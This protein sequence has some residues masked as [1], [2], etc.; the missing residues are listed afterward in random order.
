MGVGE[1]VGVVVGG[2]GGWCEVC[3]MIGVERRGSMGCGVSLRVLG[4]LRG[5]R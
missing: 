4:E 1:W 2:L 5:G 3:V